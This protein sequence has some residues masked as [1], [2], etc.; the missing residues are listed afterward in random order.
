MPARSNYPDL[1]SAW[2]SKRLGDYEAVEWAV[3][4]LGRATDQETVALFK[5]LSETAESDGTLLSAVKTTWKL[6]AVAARERLDSRHWWDVTAFH[7]AIKN[8]KLTRSSTIELA[9]F[10]RPRLVARPK[11][12]YADNLTEPPEDARKWVLWDFEAN[13]GSL[14]H[15]GERLNASVLSRAGISILIS[16]G[17]EAT[18]ALDRAIA[19]AD[20]VGWLEPYDHTSGR[21]H[22]VVPIT[23]GTTDNDGDNE[24][25]DPDSYNDDFAPIS[26]LLTATFEALAKSNGA[27]ARRL[28]RSWEDRKLALFVRMCAAAFYNK[29]VFSPRMAAKFLLDLEPQYF[30]RSDRFPEVAV[31]RERRWDQFIQRDVERLT[32]LLLK[33]PPAET[34]HDESRGFGFLTRLHGIECARIVDNARNVPARLSEFVEKIREA[35]SEF[36]EKIEAE[37]WPRRSFRV[38]RMPDGNAEIFVD[39]PAEEL[40]STLA[41]RKRAKGFLEGDDAEAFARKY[42]AEL[43]VAL[44]ARAG[45]DE[46]VEIAWDLLLSYPYDEPSDIDEAKNTS[47][48]IARLAL[49]LDPVHFDP[50]FDRLSYWLDA[51][52]QK[53]RDFSGAEALWLRL[54]PIS[55]A[56]ENGTIDEDTTEPDL[57]HRALNTPFGR[58]LSFYLRRCP[59]IP[60]KGPKPKQPDHLTDALKALTGRASELVANQLITHA[61]YFWRAD[62]SWLTELAISKMRGSSAEGMMLWEAFSRY[63]Q[64]PSRGLWQVLHR[65]L[66]GKLLPGQLTEEAQNRLAQIAILA[67]LLSKRKLRPYKVEPVEIRA[68]LKTTTDAARGSASWQFLREFADQGERDYDT[69]E[70]VGPQ[71]FREVWPIEPTLQ[72]SKTGQNFARIPGRVWERH[73]PKAVETLLPLI[74]PFEVWD[75]ESELGLADERRATVIKHPKETLAWINACISDE[76]GNVYGLSELLQELRAAYPE[77][78]HDLR[79]RRLLAH[80]V[81]R[82]IQRD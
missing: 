5:R 39:V 45:W 74:R 62:R 51:A 77:L 24:D 6:L 27:A 79:Y 58:L 3:D 14:H 73:F 10:V 18:T 11:G 32:G 25:R 56:N 13:S 59:T 55:A 31:L 63:A 71:F 15:I 37:E 53:A 49:A 47:E 60:G 68:A 36:P 21:V 57:T 76:W 26:R 33:G 34:I 2:V 42:R 72:S 1:V 20:E 35:D 80:S 82:A 65:P 75:V 81:P 52:D 69:W 8:G 44:Q 9:D 40:I 16:L 23:P 67:W 38:G 61:N 28:I 41:E 78:I 19:T 4:R 54:V 30:W 7:A 48:S 66:L 22:S 12:P 43:L 17:N 70:A 64:M 29:K 50:L 46:D